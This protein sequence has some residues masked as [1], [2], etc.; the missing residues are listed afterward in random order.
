VASS[1]IVVGL[2]N[3]GKTYRATRHNIGFWVL[4]RLALRLEAT[5]R[6]E[7]ELRRYAWVARTRLAGENVV[8]AK[9]RTYMNRSGRAVAALCRAFDV[10]AG[11]LLVVFDDADLELGRLRVRRGGGAGGHNGV[12]SMIEVLGEDAFTRIRLGIRGDDRDEG[13]LADYVLSEFT[14]DEL[15]LADPLAELGADAVEYLLANGLSATMNR[16]NGTKVGA[17]SDSTREQ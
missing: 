14:D 3:P 10:E 2:G 5:F 16:Y 7:G 9:P 4:D 6:A 1:T 8:L 17:D 13:E 12:R 15:P 11:E